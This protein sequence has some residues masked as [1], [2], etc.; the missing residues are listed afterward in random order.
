MNRY[1]EKIL[2]LGPIAR[3]TGSGVIDYGAVAGLFPLMLSGAHSATV[4]VTA[5]RAD[6]RDRAVQVAHRCRRRV[7]GS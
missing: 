1:G 7:R 6:L 2:R 3:A 5:K 4:F